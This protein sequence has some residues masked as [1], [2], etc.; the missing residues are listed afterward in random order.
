MTDCIIRPVVGKATLAEQAY[1]LIRQRIFEGVYSLGSVVSRREIAEELGMSMIPVYEALARLE[2]EY[3][4]QNLP[5][6]GTRVRIPSPEDLRGFFTVREAL[7]THAAR[8]FVANATLAQ[9]KHLLKSSRRV[10]AARRSITGTNKPEREKVHEWRCLHMGFHREIAECAD[11]PMLTAAVERNQLL[12]FNWLYDQ[13][14]G[15]LPLPGDWHEQLA[16]VLAGKSET[17]AEQAMRIHLKTRLDDLLRCLE[18][19]VALDTRR[20]RRRKAL[21]TRL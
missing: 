13:S 2:S 6:K 18:A 7:E 19:I 4:V 5:R 14:Y 17:A 3:L 21:P 10:D 8:L 1:N 16:L 20:T 9:R 11:L 12:V 15:N